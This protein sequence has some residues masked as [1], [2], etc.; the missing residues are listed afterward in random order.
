M[1][2]VNLLL[3]FFVA[4]LVLL[5]SPG[6]TSVLMLSTGM[7]YGFGP[8]LF[9]GLGISSAVLVSSLLV[10]FGLSDFLARAPTTLTTLRVLGIGYLLYLA[11]REVC[12]RPPNTAAQHSSQPNRFWQHCF[13][14]GF[15]VDVLNPSGLIFLLVFLPQF[16][17]EGL[18]HVRLQLVTLALCYTATDLA[19]NTLLAYVGGR[20]RQHVSRQTFPLGFQLGRQALGQ[21]SPSAGRYVLPAVYAVLAF[22]FAAQLS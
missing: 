20:A 14:R 3:A 7:S 16:V 8:A 2:D 18:G 9:T 1:L 12:S 21:Q 4:V 6:P 11:V 15:L 19:F 22:Y 13:W 10:V 5:V 17:N